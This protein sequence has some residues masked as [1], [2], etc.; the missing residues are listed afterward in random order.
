MTAPT[1][2]LL[3]RADERLAPARAL[4][5]PRLVLPGVQPGVWGLRAEL[6][7]GFFGLIEVDGLIDELAEAGL[8]GRGGAGFPAH[9]KWR[10]VAAAPGDKVVVANGHEGEPASA[11]DRWLLLHRPHLVLDGAFLAARAVG[12]TRLVFYVSR[13]DTA[14]SVAGAFADVRA[15]GL[16]PAGLRVDIH[17][18]EHTYVA[19]E[20]T[21]AI[22]S[23]NG[24][25]AL[26]VAKPPRPFEK[27]VDDLPTL[28][29]NVETLAHAAWIA[30]HGAAAFRE[31]GTPTS[32]GTALFTLLGCA[33]PGVYEAPLGT[34]IGDLFAAAGGVPGD[35]A[36]LL[37]GGWF[38]GLLRGDVSALSCCY[39]AVRTAG[40]G[41]GCASITA[42]GPDADLI[43]VAAELG[44]WFEAESARQC[45]VCLNGTKAIAK[46]LTDVAAGDRDPKHAEN[47][48][49]WG[50]TL[51]G[52]GACAFL[53]GATTLARSAAATLAAPTPGPAEPVPSLAKGALLV[54]SGAASPAKSELLVADATVSPAKGALLAN[55]AGGERASGSSADTSLSTRTDEGN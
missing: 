2:E 54:A 4:G 42:L 9:I 33:E 55:Q 14:A 15:A 48:A 44:R 28:V 31:L 21:A 47:L 12:A 37:M 7:L 46:T 32:P 18:A 49:R 24:G 5:T 13:A 45:G 50:T 8:R 3:P 20:E 36:G 35:P 43:A 22:R 23:I 10:T 30:R 27:G 29:S 17:R 26:P 11:K 41:L 53:D 52:R 38:G 16:V 19:G 25:P 6:D 1:I 51:T 34:S 39:D 40:S